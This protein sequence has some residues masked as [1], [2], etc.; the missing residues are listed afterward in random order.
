MNA[1]RWVDPD[2]A[3]N[4]KIVPTAVGFDEVNRLLRQARTCRLEANFVTETLASKLVALAD[5]YEEQAQSAE[6]GRRRSAS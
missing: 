3:D 4:R 1:D 5:L 6:Q 2:A